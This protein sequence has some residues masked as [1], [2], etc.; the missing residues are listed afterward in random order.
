MCAKNKFRAKFMKV[1]TGQE[2]WQFASLYKRGF[3]NP[4]DSLP[5]G[6]VQVTD[7]EQYTG[8]KDIEGNEVFEGDIIECTI[9]GAFFD[10]IDRVIRE[11]VEYDHETAMFICREILIDQPPERVTTGQLYTDESKVVGNIHQD[12]C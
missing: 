5:S 11:V 8:K 12:K 7:W 10:G 1:S 2:I 6:Y 9:D 3:C 4:Y